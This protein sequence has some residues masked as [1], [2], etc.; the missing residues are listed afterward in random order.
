MYEST[1]VSMQFVSTPFPPPANLLNA[2]NV[3]TIQQTN[4]LDGI[5]SDPL[6]PAPFSGFDFFF[7]FSN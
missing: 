4:I 6:S 3:K 7:R 1:S 2:E 5:K